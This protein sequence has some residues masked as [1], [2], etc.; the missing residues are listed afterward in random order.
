MGAADSTL[1]RACETLDKLARGQ[2][3][4]LPYP[5]TMRT[6]AALA[7]AILLPACAGGAP[8]AEPLAEPPIEVNGSGTHW[9]MHLTLERPGGMWL[10]FRRK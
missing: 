3:H 6:A 7:L 9:W 4:A 10:I 2:K 5:I 8:P 1:A